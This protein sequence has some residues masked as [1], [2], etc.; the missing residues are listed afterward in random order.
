V[1]SPPTRA[2]PGLRHLDARTLASLFVL[3]PDMAAL[4]TEPNRLNNQALVR[5]YEDEWREW[6]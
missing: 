2:L 1:I 6:N 3:G 4:P 5:Y